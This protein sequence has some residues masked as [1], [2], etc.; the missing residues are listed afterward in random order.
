LLQKL[1]N[2]EFEDSWRGF[3]AKHGSFA[4]GILFGAAVTLGSKFLEAWF[5][6]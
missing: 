6:L 5:N 2:E 4:A 1:K 3:F